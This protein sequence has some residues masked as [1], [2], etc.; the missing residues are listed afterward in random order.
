[1]RAAGHDVTFLSE[2][3]NISETGPKEVFGAKIL[4]YPRPPFP[5]KLWLMRGLYNCYGYNKSLEK[6]APNHDAYFCND[7]EIVFSLKR[8]GNLRPVI[9]R[10]EGT[11]AGDRATWNVA[12]GASTKD[13]LY[14][15]AQAY[16]DD[17]VSRAA[18]AR[19]DA[20]LVKSSIIEEELINYY[21]MPSEKIATIPNGVDYRHFADAVADEKV[22][23]E[24]V[25]EEDELRIIFVG[26]LSQVKNLGFLVRAL[27]LMRSR[28]LARLI[29]VG[30]GSEREAI[31]LL[32]SELGIGERVTFLGHKDNVAPYLAACHIFALPSQYETIANCLLEAM[33][34][35]LPCVALQPGTGNVRTSS[36]EVIVNGRTGFLSDGNEPG[37]MAA[38]L[39]LLSD[40][41][42]LRQTVGTT[43][44]DLIRARFSWEG[45]A[46]QYVDLAQRCR[47]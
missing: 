33:A 20:L 5:E 36:D 14:R 42:A 11:R 29:I 2:T 28:T 7:P 31:S 41:P 47:S 15:L 30:D 39:D 40:N 9:A 4:Y 8:L 43:G 17:A 34:A 26:R 25:A 24:V 23:A 16:L 21:G 22:L 12:N 38:H 1:M 35:G 44:Q 3:R 37:A 13:R 18:W 10:V 27:A 46:K 45:C 6:Y 32:A 19:C